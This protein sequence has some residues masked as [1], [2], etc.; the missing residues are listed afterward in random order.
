MGRF[1]LVRGSLSSLSS[2]PLWS[3]RGLW[4]DILK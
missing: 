2:D 3:I 4:I 1:R